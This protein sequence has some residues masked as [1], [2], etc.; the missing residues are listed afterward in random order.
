M[1]KQATVGHSVSLYLSD[2]IGEVQPQLDRIAAVV[3]SNLR[4]QK[5]DQCVLLCG[6]N[7]SCKS[8]VCNYV[9]TS[10]LSQ[11]HNSQTGLIRHRLTEGSKLLSLLTGCGKDTACVLAT[12]LFMEPSEMRLVGGQFS[13]MLMNT[14]VLGKLQ[15]PIH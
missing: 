3:L 4:S 5:E 7:V 14:A 8:L 1:H 15:V 13:Y 9:V 11:L 2:S 6:L 10:T 12:T